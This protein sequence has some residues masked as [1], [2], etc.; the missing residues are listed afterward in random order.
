MRNKQID[1]LP[2]TNFLLQFGPL[3][4][5]LKVLFFFKFQLL[6]TSLVIFDIAQRRVYM[7]YGIVLL[8]VMLFVGIRNCLCFKRN[9][10]GGKHLKKNYAKK[11]FRRLEFFNFY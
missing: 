6:S 9:F 7:V 4:C 10:F 3:I 11:L 2:I 1:M 8:D 5:V